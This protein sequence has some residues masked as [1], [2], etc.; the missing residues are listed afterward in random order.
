MVCAD[1]DK[2]VPTYCV[3]ETDATGWFTIEDMRTL[4]LHPGLRQHL[5]ERD[6]CSDDN[7]PR[8]EHQILS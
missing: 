7:F 8:K 4:P 5:R 1:V 3:R 6:C 2:P